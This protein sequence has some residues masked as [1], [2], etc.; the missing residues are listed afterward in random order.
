ML[1]YYWLLESYFLVYFL[2]S[3]AI[4]LSFF[5]FIEV[6]LLTLLQHL[7]NIV[8]SISISFTVLALLWFYDYQTILKET[9]TEIVALAFQC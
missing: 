6:N 4:Y 7:I 2:L 1:S 8:D 5:N 9:K 3:I